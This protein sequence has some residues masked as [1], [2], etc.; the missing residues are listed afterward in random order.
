MIFY[1]LWFATKIADFGYSSLDTF[2]G[3][4]KLCREGNK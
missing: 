1:A 3:I 4:L 2:E